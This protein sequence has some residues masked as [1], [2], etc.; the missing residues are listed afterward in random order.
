MADAAGAAIVE[1]W[2]QGCVLLTGGTG[3]VGLDIARVFL[4]AGA[5]VVVAGSDPGRTDA[6]RAA[7]AEFPRA[8]AV[9]C[10]LGAAGGVSALLEALPAAAGP[11][12]VLVNGAGINF[13]KPVAEVTEA[14]FDRLFAVNVRAAFLATQAVCERMKAEGR[15]GRVVNITSGNYRYVRPDAG[16]YSATKSALEILTRSFALEYGPVGVTVNAVAPGLMAREGATD[17][18]Y[19]RIA[20]YYRANSPVQRIASGTDVG[21][22][23]LFLASSRAA[24][25]TGETI[26]V[27][28][29]YSAG[30]FDF[31]TRSQT[32]VPRS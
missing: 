14:D 27:D 1:P 24:N 20:D 5:S 17:P 6:A 8:Y 30:R 15:T 4:R 25:I 32:Q 18:G 31:P 19:R 16:L 28:G 2:L 23:A 3:L 7:L 21:E 10:D 22:A 29:G 9:A 13:A 26:V 12:S 11:V